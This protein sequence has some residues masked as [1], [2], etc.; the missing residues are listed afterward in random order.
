MAKKTLNVVLQ[1]FNDL[2]VFNRLTA[3]QVNFFTSIPKAIANEIYLAVSIAAPN[4]PALSPSKG[5]TI[6]VSSV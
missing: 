2:L 1:R 3:V 6:F 4:T 5:F